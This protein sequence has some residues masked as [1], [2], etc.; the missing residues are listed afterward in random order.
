MVAVRARALQVAA[1][2]L[3]VIEDVR[4]LEP[5][6]LDLHVSAH[7]RER[8]EDVSRRPCVMDV[9]TGTTLAIVGH[10]YLADSGCN[11]VE[12]RLLRAA[13]PAL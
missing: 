11:G 3:Q 1:N 8:A 6:R 2:A 13:H 5:K 9:R 7:S 10:E 12:P 4:V